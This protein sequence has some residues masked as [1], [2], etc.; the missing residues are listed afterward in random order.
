MLRTTHQLK[1]PF[2]AIHANTQLLLGGYCGPI[3]A[4]RRH[5]IGQIAERCE[6]LSREIKAMLQLAN[7]RSHAHGPPRAG[8]ARSADW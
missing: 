8:G 6:M 1:A 2:A 4:A 5:V 3:S 7:L